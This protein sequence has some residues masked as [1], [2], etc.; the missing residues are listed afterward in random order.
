[1]AKAIITW[2]Y[3][4]G[5]RSKWTRA[6]D[7]RNYEWLMKIDMKWFKMV[8]KYHHDEMW[9]IKE[10]ETMT[11]AEPQGILTLRS[12]ICGYC[13]AIT[14]VVILYFPKYFPPSK[15]FPCSKNHWY[16]KVQNLTKIKKTWWFK[17]LQNY[18]LDREPNRGQNPRNNSNKFVLCKIRIL[19]YRPL[20]YRSSS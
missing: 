5:S 20:F 7:D 4:M 18:S 19:T 15:Y 9:H 8:R 2:T 14:V 10:V 17:E 1:M 12:K 11:A 3:M 13:V 16:I 6:E